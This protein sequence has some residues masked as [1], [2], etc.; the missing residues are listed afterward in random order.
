MKY[1]WIESGLVRDVCAGSPFT[2]YHPDIAAHYSESVPDDAAIGDEWDGVTLT[3]PPPP[4][5]YV[6]PPYVP[7]VDPCQWLIDIGPF[8]DRFGAAKMAVLTSSDAAVK[9]ILQDIQVR[10]WIDLQRADVI[11][12]LAYVGSVVPAITPA[13]RTAILTTPVTASENM[14][15]RRLYF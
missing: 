1:A 12:A 11:S 14:A 10:K 2:L 15:L 3:K 8:F 9:A 6:P 7:P 4:P 5:P 13:L